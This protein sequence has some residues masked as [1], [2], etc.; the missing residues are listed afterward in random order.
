[1]NKQGPN[2]NLYLH[3]CASWVGVET[4]EL[5]LELEL[6]PPGLELEMELIF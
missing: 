5:E 3:T 1:M 2:Y 6:K 4:L